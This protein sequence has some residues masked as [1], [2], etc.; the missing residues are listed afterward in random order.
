[1]LE[2]VR[3]EVHPP[4]REV[5]KRRLADRLGEPA[6]ERGPRHVHLARQGG[7]RPVLA[8]PLVQQGEH[9]RDRRA[10]RC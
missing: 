6:A 3:G 4:A 8:R 9:G 5:R 2:P 10:A 1:V 7:K